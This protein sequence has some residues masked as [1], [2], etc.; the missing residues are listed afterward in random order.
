MISRIRTTLRGFG[1]IDVPDRE[2]DE[3]PP[4]G[5]VLVDESDGDRLYVL[6]VRNAAVGWISPHK[7]GFDS[8]RDWRFS[9]RFER[10][11]N[12]K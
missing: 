11:K 1:V 4:G 2:M 10:S 7:L 8:V 12:E 9:Q 5:R 3:V 6:D